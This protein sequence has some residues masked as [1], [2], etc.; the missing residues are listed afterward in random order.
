M[1][2]YGLTVNLFNFINKALRMHCSWV[3]ITDNTDISIRLNSSKQPQA[4][5]WQ[6]PARIWPTARKSIPSPQLVTT[7]KRPKA[8]ARSFVVSVLPV[9]AGPIVFLRNNVKCNFIYF[10]LTWILWFMYLTCR[11]SSK[12]HCQSLC[13]SKIDPIGKRCD[14]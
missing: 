3:D 10:F 7:H 4:P 8:F 12:L 6:S 14:H 1:N 13:Y 2:L 11:S 9:P 5:H